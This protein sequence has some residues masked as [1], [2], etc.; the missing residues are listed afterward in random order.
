MSEDKTIE[1]LK[2]AI[3]LEKR[4]QAFYGKVAEQA[5]GQAV[6]E[7]FEM[8]ADEEDKHVIIL[9][10]QFKAYQENKE[11]TPREYD[12]NFNG[13]VAPSVLTDEL[14]QQ[15][16][17]ADYEAAAISAAMSMEENA[18]KLY[19]SRGEEAHDPNEKALY[20]WLADWERQHLHFLS[21][22]DKEITQQIWHDNSF[23]PF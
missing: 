4:G 14:K 10:D 8:M 22:I 23:W 19:S 3:L 11:F 7:F 17:A 18:I 1:I 2:N 5:G 21:Q 9:S 13:N 15:L 6:K 12:N 16:S 20:R